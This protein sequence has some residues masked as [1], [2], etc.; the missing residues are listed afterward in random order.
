[1]GCW[2]DSVQ[3]GAEAIFWIILYGIALMVL[4]PDAPA[5]DAALPRWRVGLRKLVDQ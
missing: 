1:M 3:A 2:R 5:K 4:E